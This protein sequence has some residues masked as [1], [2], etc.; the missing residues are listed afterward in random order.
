MSL[1][2]ILNLS[3]LIQAQLSCLPVQDFSLSQDISKIFR[4]GQRVAK[5]MC[6]FI[7]KTVSY[8]MLRLFPF[9]LFFVCLFFLLFAPN[10]YLLIHTFLCHPLFNIHFFYLARPYGADVS[11]YKLFTA[12]SLSADL[13][14]IQNKTLV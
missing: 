7:Y 14:S 11:W 5:C 8:T 10:T 2:H 3:S 1:T 12:P 9:F 6:F 4:V 13:P